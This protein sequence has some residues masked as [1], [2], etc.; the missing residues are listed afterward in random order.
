MKILGREEIRKA[1]QAARA[2]RR[3]KMSEIARRVG[4]T[5]AMLNKFCDTGYGSQQHVDKLVNQLRE[6]RFIKNA[7]ELDR[8]KRKETQCE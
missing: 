6:L 5:L 7:V 1:A 4:W 8:L 3:I 2:D